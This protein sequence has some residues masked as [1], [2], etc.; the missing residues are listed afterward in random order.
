VHANSKPSPLL[1]NITITQF[2][3]LADIAIDYIQAEY[4]RP[5]EDVAR[6]NVAKEW[7]KDRSADSITSAEI[8]E[9][10][11]EAAD[12]KK[13]SASTANHHHNVISLCFRLGMEREKV[14]ESPTQL[15]VRKQKREQQSCEVPLSG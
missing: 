11:N 3:E 13:W 15:K 8:R 7:F 5:A 10:L 9:K 4:S 1:V 6:V 14:K 12:R 2:S